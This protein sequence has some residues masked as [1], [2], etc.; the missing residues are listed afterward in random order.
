[1]CKKT[2]FF[3]IL[4]AALAANRTFAQSN[5]L[6][7]QMGVFHCFFD[8]TPMLNVNYLGKHNVF[9]VFGGFFLNSN[10]LEYV[11]SLS[12][13]E[14][15]SFEFVSYR[16]NYN[17]HTRMYPFTERLVGWRYFT[18]G[19]VNYVR[20]IELQ[21][22]LSFT[23]GGGVHFRHGSES[24][25]VN[26]HPLGYDENGNPLGYELNLVTLQ[27]NDFAINLSTGIE[28]TPKKWLTLY[29]KIDLLSFVYVH[30]RGT[31]KL[32]KEVYDTPQ[33]PSRFDLSLKFGIG[34]NF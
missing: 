27:R 8:K 13:R 25:I 2:F 15:L 24:I 17:K 14:A 9:D 4:F 33:Y 5:S 23:Y 34:F 21:E 10:G 11:R 20:K 7:L 22:K 3:L 26:K 12:P 30:D 16:Q 31:A 1:M 32:L 6:R 29:S 18:T 28:Y 19:G